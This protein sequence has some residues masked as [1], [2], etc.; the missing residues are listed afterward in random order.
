M[1]VIQAKQKVGKAVGAA[2]LPPTPLNTPSLKRETE[3]N[4][5]S[6]RAG[7]T[8]NNEDLSPSLKGLSAPVKPAPWA[9]SGALAEVEKAEEPK[10][11]P[12]ST[13]KQNARSW[14]NADDSDDDERQENLPE[15][16][17]PDNFRETAEELPSTNEQPKSEDGF[18]HQRY[19]PPAR[20][21]PTANVSPSN[22]S[23]SH[24]RLFD[25][26]CIYFRF[27]FSLYHVCN[28]FQPL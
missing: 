15:T 9:K 22:F 19:V 28:I 2:A 16:E 4:Q 10:A 1:Q 17:W 7:Q 6:L 8:S 25:V 11:E 5:S 24:S 18:G 21:K 26:E 14:A 13:S 27:V 12:V 3:T 23:K 20:N